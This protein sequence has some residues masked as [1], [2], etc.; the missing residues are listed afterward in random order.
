MS[1]ILLCVNPLRNDKMLDL[2]KFKVFANDSVAKIAKYV[3]GRVENTVGNREIADYH[4][5]CY[6]IH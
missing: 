5:I 2:S 4:N 3:C 6:L 1:K